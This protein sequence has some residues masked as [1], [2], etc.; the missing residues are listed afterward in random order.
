MKN[1]FLAMLLTM[2]GFYLTAQTE[3]WH[4]EDPKKNK[5]Q[6]VSTDEAYTFL[7]KKGRTSKKVVVAIIDSGVDVE[8][9]DLKD[10]IWTNEDEIPETPQF[11]EQETLIKE[12]HGLPFNQ[13][14]YAG[15]TC[16]TI[17]PF[18]FIEKSWVTAQYKNFSAEEL[19]ELS[20]SCEKSN[21]GCGQ[22]FHCK[23]REWSIEHSPKYLVHTI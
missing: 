3:D 20:K 9:E 13:K 18:Y 15:K 22:C 23:E 1:I 16:T 12:K 17:T 2:S 7:K 5:I 6:G 10:N 21:E 19:F 11:R 4:H 14:E 8:H